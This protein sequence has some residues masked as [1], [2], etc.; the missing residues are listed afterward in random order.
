MATDYETDG[1]SEEAETRPA[2]GVYWLPNLFTTGTLFGGFYA[3]VAAIDGNFARAGIGVFVAIH[4]AWGILLGATT[5]V[6]MS[7]IS[8]AAGSLQQGYILGIAQSTAQFSSIAGI[9]LG[10][11][12]MQ[13]AGLQYTYF[14]VSFSYALAVIFVLTMRR[15]QVAAQPKMS[16]RQ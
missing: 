8:K 15:G 7:L 9:A 13:T 11:W 12:L 6:L 3:I 5:P 2:R 1:I 10:G 14:F 16:P 4:F